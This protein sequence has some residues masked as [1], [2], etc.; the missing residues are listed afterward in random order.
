[1]GGP[2][3]WK[4]IWAAAGPGAAR[5]A[6]QRACGRAVGALPCGRAPAVRVPAAG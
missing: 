3:P 1:M 6:E 5:A 2:E 4:P